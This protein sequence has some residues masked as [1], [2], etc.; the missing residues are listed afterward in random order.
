MIF[1]YWASVSF[2][3]IGVDGD[4]DQQVAGHRQENDDGQKET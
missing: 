3:P 1:R 4:A 2:L